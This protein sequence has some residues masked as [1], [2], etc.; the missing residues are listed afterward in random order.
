M[1][2][3][4]GNFNPN[5]VHFNEF[6]HYVYRPIFLVELAKESWHDLAEVS[7]P[8]PILTLW[9]HLS[10]YHVPS[11]LL[12]ISNAIWEHKDELLKMPTEEQKQATAT[13]MMAY[14]HLL[15]MAYAV[16]GMMVHLTT[17]RQPRNFPAN[18]ALQNFTSCKNFHAI[19]C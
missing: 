3:L 16:D 1:V 11:L 14:Y 8:G 6:L 18:I 10:A 15:R 5:Q 12:R 2:S 7:V 4:E 17:S 9:R 19:N 13:H